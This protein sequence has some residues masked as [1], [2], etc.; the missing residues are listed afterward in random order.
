MS[1]TGR[2]ARPPLA[3]GPPISALKTTVLGRK[4]IIFYAV[5]TVAQLSVRCMRGAQPEL[6]SQPDGRV[7]LG[8]K[9]PLPQAPTGSVWSL[10]IF[11]KSSVDSENLD[12]QLSPQIFSQSFS[13]KFTDLL[14]DLG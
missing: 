14:A 1:D 5:F 9:I 7:Y 11:G 10:P 8:T 6:Q 2:P 12:L 4:P 3:S 13:V